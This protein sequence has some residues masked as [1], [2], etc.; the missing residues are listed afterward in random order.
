M[1]SEHGCLTTLTCS[2]ALVGRVIG[3]HGT[4][5]KGVQLF[6]GAVVDVDQMAAPTPI[7]RIIGTKKAVE[8]ANNMIVDIIAGKFKGF[9]MLREIVNRVGTKTEECER[10]VLKDDIATESVYAK[11]LGI[12]PRRQVGGVLGVG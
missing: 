4:T 7:I 2:R 10:D 3:N 11:D 1:D 9:A 6:T 12:F 5:V 8:T